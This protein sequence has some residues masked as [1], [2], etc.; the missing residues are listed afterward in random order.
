MK[1]RS[2]LISCMGVFGSRFMYVRARST[3]SRSAASLKEAGSGMRPVTRATIPGLVPQVT[4]GSIEVA[5]ISTTLSKDAP[6]SVGS[7]LH[8][9]TAASNSLPCGT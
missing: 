7:I 3:P 9:S 2:I 5:S 4:N 6:G 8:R 1:T